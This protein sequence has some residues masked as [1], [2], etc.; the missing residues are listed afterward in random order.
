MEEHEISVLAY[1]EAWPLK[2]L[3]YGNR[4]HLAFRMLKDESRHRYGRK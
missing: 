3:E 1:E 4:T 2:L